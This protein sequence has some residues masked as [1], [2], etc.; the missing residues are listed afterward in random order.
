MCT[1]AESLPFV[2]ERPDVPCPVHYDNHHHRNGSRTHSR[3]SHHSQEKTAPSSVISFVPV[4]E[5]HRSVLYRQK[6]MPPP[7]S[8]KKIQPTSR[9]VKP[10]LLQIGNP[11]QS[12][13]Q[14]CH[15]H[16]NHGKPDV[17]PRHHHD[18]QPVLP[19]RKSE[20]LTSSNHVREDR[21]K[22]KP[23]VYQAVVV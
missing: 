9:D 5:E 10:D 18:D 20:E 11:V 15:A 23:K 6:S 7:E 16:G 2:P 19:R 8:S 21:F 3:H 4:L 22:A 14:S 13:R 17:P 12:H 1:S